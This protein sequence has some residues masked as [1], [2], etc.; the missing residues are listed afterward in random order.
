MGTCLLLFVWASAAADH[1][2][3]MQRAGGRVSAPRGNGVD[4]LR[5]KARFAIKNGADWIKGLAD[6]GVL[7]EEESVGAPPQ[8]SQAE[9]DAVVQEATMWG[10]R[11]ACSLAR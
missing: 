9:L 6:A 7:S 2:S 8:Y 3:A 10:R 4:E 1:G 5:K 11:V